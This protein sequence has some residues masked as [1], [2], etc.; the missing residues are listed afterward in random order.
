MYVEIMFEL[1]NFTLATFLNAEFGLRGVLVNTEVQVPYFWGFLYKAGVL[2]KLIFLV[3]R[4]LNL[5]N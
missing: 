3:F 4:F 1:T 2:F 5:V